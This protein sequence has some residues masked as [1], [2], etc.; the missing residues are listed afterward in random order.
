MTKEYS[1]AEAKRV[2]RPLS[3]HLQ[4]YRP[5]LTSITSIP[6]ASTLRVR[7]AANDPVDSIPNLSIWPSPAAQSI[8]AWYPARVA[9]NSGLC[10]VL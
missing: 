1:M 9:G 8:M 4:I 6:A 10:Q 3:P 5:Q 7:S 2:E